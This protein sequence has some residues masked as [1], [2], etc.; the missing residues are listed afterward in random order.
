M[1]GTFLNSKGYFNQQLFEATKRLMK[2][3]DV[4]FAAVTGKQCE[5]VEELLGPDAKD[6]YILGDS[7]TR[8]KHNHQYVYQSL[9][10]NQ[11][12]LAIVAKLEQISQAHTII[13]CTEEGAFIKATTVTEEREIVRRSYRNLAIVNHYHDIKDDFIKITVHDPTAHCFATAA[14]MN[15]FAKQAYIVASEAA[16][17][18]IANANVHKG[19][20][21]AQLQKLLNIR[22]E[23][24]M[25]FGDGNNDIEL[26]KT[27]SYSF[28]VSNAI[29]EVKQA[30]RYVTGTNDEDAVLHT[31]NHLL[32]LQQC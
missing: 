7:A 21:V 22:S 19:T 26:M 32:A 29:A 4:V 18:D 8:I 20:T 6:F 10:A 24:T 23:Q 3:Q 31:I 1:D 28:A 9:L 30:A 15:Q 11:I 14:Q 5:R 13:V 27:G 12:G 25:V 16:W 2:A 17:L